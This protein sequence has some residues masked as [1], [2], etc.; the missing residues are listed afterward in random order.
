MLAAR[1]LGLELD[2]YNLLDAQLG[3]RR[4]NVELTFFV[5]N[6]LDDHYESGNYFPSTW[7]LI[8]SA[9][10]GLDPRTTRGIV[11]VPGSVFGVRVSAVF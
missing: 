7:Q 3:I 8:Y 1:E 6:A 5:R 10:S 9:A 11:R 2:S 4:G